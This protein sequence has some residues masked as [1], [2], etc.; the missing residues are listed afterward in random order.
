MLYT[1]SR[2]KNNKIYYRRTSESIDANH[3]VVEIGYNSVPKNI[4]QIFNRDVFII[5]YVISGN[6]RCMGKKFSRNHCYFIVPGELEITE[7]SPTGSYECC[8]IMLK[9]EN[10]KELVSKCGLPEHN[11]VFPFNSAN[12]CAKIIQSFLFNQKYENE[13]IEACK[14]E[15]LLYKLLSFHLKSNIANTSS[16]YEKNNRTKAKMIAKYIENNYQFNIKISDLCSVFHLSTNHLCN[17]FKE[18]YNISPKEYLIRYR[19]SKAKQ[20]LNDAHHNIS[21][22]EISNAVGIDNP[23][24]FSRLFHQKEGVSPSD[25]KK[26]LLNKDDSVGSFKN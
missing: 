2:T 13:L 4:R 6:G 9:G 19:I 5:H 23:L 12:E 7:S 22:S 25:Y 3:H 26:S 1:L 20:L 18:R 10:S 11:S 8:W 17:I 15:E 21:I 16:N 24:Y 14:L